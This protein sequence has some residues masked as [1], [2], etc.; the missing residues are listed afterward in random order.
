MNF[1]GMKILIKKSVRGWSGTE[2]VVRHPFVPQINSK[3]SYL[4]FEF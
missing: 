3:I 4:P 1:Y 2:G